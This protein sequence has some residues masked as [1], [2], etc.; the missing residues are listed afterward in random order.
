ME[1]R[2]MVHSIASSCKSLV[3]AMVL[4]LCLTYILG[5]FIT[6]LIADA[7]STQPQL[8][9]RTTDLH[10][11]YG[12]L[13]RALMSLF[14]ATTGGL[15]WDVMLRPLVRDVHPLMAI[16]FA[17]YIGF[18]LLAM[19]NVI[20]GIF[21]DQALD[22]AKSSKDMDLR[23]HMRI[24][25]LQTDKDSSG[26]LSWEE[27]DS[28][29]EDAD[30][31]RCFKMLDIDNSEAKGLFTLLDTDMSG[32]IDAEEFVMGCLRLKGNAKAID[33]ATLMYF[34][35]RMATWWAQQMGAVRGDLHD[36]LCCLCM[37]DELAEAPGAAGGHAEGEDGRKPKRVSMEALPS[38]TA[39]GNPSESR[40]L[41]VDSIAGFATWQG[42]KVEGSLE[43][44]RTLRPSA[45]HSGTASTA[46]GPESRSSS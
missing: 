21:V 18:T 32:E 33:L 46:T 17:M 31:V 3:W 13:P 35:K 11:Y 10:L 19:M 44:S 42:L 40:S 1:L 30:M 9:D 38:R 43:S 2:I 20:T 8:L 26:V 39:S 22:T 12:D 6:G 27:F 36:I 34:N 28:K 15:D 24:L 37:D 5:V 7:A 23:S 25:F 41:G 4:F 45:D 14:Q 29:L 16:P